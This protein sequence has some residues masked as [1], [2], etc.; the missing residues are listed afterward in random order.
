[1][2]FNGQVSRPNTPLRCTFEVCEIQCISTISVNNFDIARPALLSRDGHFN[3]C[4]TSIPK[5][6]NCDIRQ[7]ICIGIGAL[8]VGAKRVG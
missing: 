3:G 8:H 6:S 4:T 2:Q 5:P 7:W 1:M